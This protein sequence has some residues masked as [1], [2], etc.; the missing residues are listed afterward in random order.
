[1]QRGRTKVLSQEEYKILQ[2]SDKKKRKSRKANFG[3]N[4][5]FNDAAQRFSIKSGKKITVIEQNSDGINI[6]EEKDGENVTIQNPKEQL[7][8][9]ENESGMGKFSFDT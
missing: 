9:L 3:P 5:R 4:S 8:F 1:M 7:H 6:F 2:S